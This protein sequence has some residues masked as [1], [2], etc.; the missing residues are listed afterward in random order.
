MQNQILA[1]TNFINLA[2]G[3]VARGPNLPSGRSLECK[4]CKK[5][6]NEGAGRVWMIATPY[7]QKPGQELLVIKGRMG[8][9]LLLPP[10]VLQRLQK[11]SRC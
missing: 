11:R 7:D 3:T 6:K 10:L 5:R 2:N 4:K 8:G 1:A 9:A